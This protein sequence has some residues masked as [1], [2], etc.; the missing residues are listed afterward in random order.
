MSFGPIYC[1][2]GERAVEKDIKWN[3]VA[4]KKKKNIFAKKLLFATQKKNYSC[5]SKKKKTILAT[6][7]KLIDPI[8]AR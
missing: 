3:L 5:I 4:H 7:R 8:S 1:L 2:P 6:Q